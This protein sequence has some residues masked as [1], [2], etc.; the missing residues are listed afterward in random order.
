MIDFT[1]SKYIQLIG[2]LGIGTLLYLI[3]YFGP[4]RIVV[5]TLIL[6]AP[7]QLITSSHATI[8]T[9]LV[10]IV[11]IAFYLRGGLKRFPL[12]TPMIIILFA[13]LLSLTQVDRSTLL[14]NVS[15]IVAILSNFV[16]FHIVYNYLHETRD[17]RLIINTFTLLN[18]FVLLYGL[19]LLTLG[20]NVAVFG[21]EE[22]S[23]GRNRAD[24]LGGP[25][26]AV[27]ITA[28]Y[29]VIQIMLL[30][31]LSLN[32][33]QM[34]RKKFYYLLIC[35]NFSYL[36]ATGNRGGLLVLVGGVALFLFVFRKQFNKI[37]MISVILTGI[38]MFGAGTYLTFRYTE[39]NVLFQRL[40]NT[41]FVEGGIPDSRKIVWPEAWAEIVKKPLIGHRP[42]LTIPEGRE[43]GME[44]FV[45]ISSPHNL[46]LHLLFTVGV[47]G[48]LAFLNFFAFLMYRIYRGL[49]Y[50][51]GDPILD[52]L[53]R[54]GMIILI[55]FLVDQIKI[56]FLRFTL[57]DYQHVVFIYLASFVG[58]SDILKERS[59]VVVAPT[60]APLPGVLV[61]EQSGGSA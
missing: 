28:E 17:Y 50:P 36:I 26:K 33:T 49:R 24:R 61:A 48:L 11:G 9:V 35:L 3:A 13:Y 46:Y 37:K 2:A 54:I 4:A 29:L 41:E 19:I 21:L 5:A 20:S 8:N 38:L 10:F 31:Y 14:L 44:G 15:Y 23:M 56:E 42:R 43:V 7:F 22:L 12:F 34:L 60:Q 25:F 45:K 58:F 51:I 47:V 59:G 27:G 57:S 6:L 16:L 32:E 55:V 18:I 39:Y 1:W 30:L 53:P 52:N 40:S